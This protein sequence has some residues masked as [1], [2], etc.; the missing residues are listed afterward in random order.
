MPKITLHELKTISEHNSYHGWPT[1]ISLDNNELIVVCSAGRERHVCPF[2]QVHLLRSSDKGKTWSQPEVLINS[3]LDDRDAGILQT[4]KGT[5]L[6]NWFTS[7]AWLKRLKKAE[8]EGRDVLEEMGDGFVSRCKKIQ[9]IIKEKGINEST[10][11]WIIR[12]ED[13]GNTF[14]NKIDCKVGS[15]HGPIELNDGRLLYVGLP[16]SKEKEVS[17]YASANPAIAVSEDDGY[18]WEKI[19]EI[20]RRSDDNIDTYKE[21]HAVQTRGGRII[22]HIRNHSQ[23][24]RG[25]ILQSESEDGGKTFS[26]PHNI[27][28]YGFPAHLL[29]LQDGRLVTTYGYRKTPYGNRVSISEDE[30]ETWSE[31]LILNE[32]TEKRDLGYPATAELSNGNLISVWYEKLPGDKLAG[33]QMA[34]WSII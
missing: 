2:G 16:R 30:G 4:S 10:G 11:P 6:V 18:S 8:K 27:G 23:Q 21:P 32:K 19:A 26:V 22:V 28:L 7:L 33:I 3:P 12:S 15:P 34:K 17:P 9:A 29:C 31:P 13:G 24:D 20:P 25:Y 1:I 5:I 14:S